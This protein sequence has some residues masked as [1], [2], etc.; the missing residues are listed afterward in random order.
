MANADPLI[1]ALR[2]AQQVGAC[3]RGFYVG[4]AV[5]AKNTLWGPGAQS[6]RDGL[7]GA[8][9]IGFDVAAAFCLQR[10]NNADVAARGAKVLKAD[11]EVAAARAL[12][13][14]P[15]LYWLGFDIGT[16]I[17]GDPDRGALGNT[18]M[19]P[20]SEKIRASLDDDGKR[21]F[22]AARDFNLRKRHV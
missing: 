20:G 11:P 3:R 7:D 12:E 22:N 1:A 4:L 19:G 10:N 8:E 14:P 9:R 2:D 15:G 6:I 13:Q 21:G 17:F 5:E 16:G 18:I